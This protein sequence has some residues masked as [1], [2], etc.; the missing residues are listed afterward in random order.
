MIEWFTF[1][2][3]GALR[4]NDEDMEE[5]EFATLSCLL[6]REQ[7]RLHKKEKQIEAL[8]KEAKEIRQRVWDISTEIERMPEEKKTL[9]LVHAT[10]NAAN[11]ADYCWWA[12]EALAKTL[13]PGDLIEVETAY[14]EAL[15]IIRRI[16]K[17]NVWAEHRRV[18]R[19]A[20]V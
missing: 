3:R 20:D 2:D 13:K 4:D 18:L 9:Y 15:A 5:S 14:G 12:N 10:H 11:K 7:Q 16:E 6:E 8:M 19:K 17:T 1:T